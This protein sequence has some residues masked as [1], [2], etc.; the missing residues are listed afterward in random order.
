MHQNTI[1]YTY[2]NELAK[3][4]IRGLAN[5]F[6]NLDGMVR[7]VLDLVPLIRLV[8]DAKRTALVRTT[9]I[10]TQQMASACVYPV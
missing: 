9:L 6:A 1:D 3:G 7:H 4:V 5:V 8:R 10:A 2:K